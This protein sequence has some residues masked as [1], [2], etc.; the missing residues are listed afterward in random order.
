MRCTPPYYTNSR[1]VTEFSFLR[2]TDESQFMVDL[3]NFNNK[4]DRRT[5]FMTNFQLLMLET[6]FYTI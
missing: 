1:Y 3:Y 4:G 2:I 6:T 5:L